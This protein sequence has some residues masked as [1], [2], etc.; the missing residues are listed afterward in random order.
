MSTSHGFTELPL[1]SKANLADYRAQIEKRA[2]KGSLRAALCL[3]QM[4]GAGLGVEKNAA[5]AY[6]WV[7]VGQR[8]G[9]RGND[10]SARNEIYEAAITMYSDLS[11]DEQAEAYRL[12][13]AMCGPSP[14]SDTKGTGS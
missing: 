12:I 7:L 3:A 6:A 9:T 8:F 14:G 5:T 11:M 10:E 4:H 1:T 2:L 13:E